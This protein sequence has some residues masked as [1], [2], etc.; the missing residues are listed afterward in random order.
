VAATEKAQ[1][2]LPCRC[3]LTPLS[4]HSHSLHGN[5]DVELVLKRVVELHCGL[6]PVQRPQDLHFSL[7]IV[8]RH[9]IRHLKMQ[10]VM[11]LFF[12]FIPEVPLISI[13]NTPCF[14]FPIHRHSS[15]H[16]YTRAV[17][18]HTQ[19]HIHTAVLTYP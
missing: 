11:S 19:S 15:T 10:T 14:H 6:L 8:H 2:S 12:L 4:L 13:L 16:M 1:H 5:V 7:H 3:I 17:L 9:R 18:S